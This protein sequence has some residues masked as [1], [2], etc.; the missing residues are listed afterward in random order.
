[1]KTKATASHEPRVEDESPGRRGSSVF[2]IAVFGNSI[3]FTPYLGSTTPL[4]A[5]IDMFALRK[6]RER[7]ASLCHR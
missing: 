1:M 7:V 2:E 5:S 4:A 3:L 6:E